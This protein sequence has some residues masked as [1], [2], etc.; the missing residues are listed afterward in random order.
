MTAG[1]GLV[2]AWA[3][4]AVAAACPAVLV[5]AARDEVGTAPFC[6]AAKLTGRRVAMAAATNNLRILGMTLEV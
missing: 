4:D 3:G 6:A 1:R 5:G 2:T